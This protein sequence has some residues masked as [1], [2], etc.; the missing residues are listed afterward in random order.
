ML[1][2]QRH[3]TSA[4]VQ[5]V[6]LKDYSPSEMR[7]TGSCISF[8]TSSEKRI[9]VCVCINS[10]PDDRKFV[11]SPSLFITWYG[12]RAPPRVVL[13]TVQ[14]VHNENS[15][16]WNDSFVMSLPILNI[17]Y[18]CMVV[19]WFCR[20]RHLAWVDANRPYH[21][22]H[23]TCRQNTRICRYHCESRY[24]HNC[25]A[26]RQQRRVKGTRFNWYFISREITNELA[27]IFFLRRNGEG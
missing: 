4:S 13:T 15:F 14:Q 12:M 7:L 16:T 18:H 1:R 2:K 22:S 11:V 27:L 25:Q 3:P 20:R 19:I 6:Y 9:F 24:S 10:T 23:I 21:G 8:A 26:L 17:S 5:N